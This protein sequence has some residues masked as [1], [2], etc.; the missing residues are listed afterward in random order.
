[1]VVDPRAPSSPGD[2]ETDVCVVGAGPAG[3]AFARECI[4]GPFRVCLLETGWF[5]KDEKLEAL[6]AGLV[7]SRHF[8]P[9]AL[10]GG[11]RR[12]FGGTANLWGYQTEPSSGRTYAR[13]VPPEPGDLIQRSWQPGSGWPCSAGQLQSFYARA[14]QLW[15]GGPFDYSIETW[16]DSATSRPSLDTSSLTSKIAQHGPSDVFT[17][18]YRDDI[19]TAPNIS[20]QLGSTAVRLESD[21]SGAV[22]QRAT[23]VRADGSTFSVTAK[24]FVLACGGVENVQLLLL[25]EATTPGGVGNRHGNVGC[26][27]TDHPE[28]RMGM[29][30]PAGPDV[31]DAIGLYD[32]H[33][34][35]QCMISGFLTLAEDVKQRERLLNVSAALVPQPAGFGTASERSLRSL[36]GARQRGRTPRAWSHV[37]TVLSSHRDTAAVL[38]A[39]LGRGGNYS[40]Y[41][42]GWSRPGVDRRRF[43]V[44]EVH[45]ATEQTAERDNSIAL[46][47][48]RD[49]M[50]RKQPTLRWRWSATDQENVAR[51]L[52]ILGEEFTSAGLG[53]YQ[54][55]VDFN[56]PVRPVY[57]GIHHP[58]G[59]TRMHEDPEQGVVNGECRVHGMENL[60]VA[61]SSVFPTGHGYANPTLTLLA[62]TIR[63]ADHVKDRM[64]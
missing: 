13:S 24:A 18:R 62:L 26:Y 43:K 55:W 10:A 37:R 3:I 59:G 32:L 64:T 63:L 53:T 44:I 16:A 61:G 21:R 20:V 25:S 22:V 31:M 51:S 14:Q 48:R 4:G 45:A 57:S 9:G 8:G 30:T 42:G 49:W 54:Q 19:F 17:L 27:V 46:S 2:I 50:G 47:D 23:V 5:E 1:M 28:F 15:N 41:Q 52:R 34:S 12:Q 36:L 11:R 58:M 40:E 38:R 7:E 29:I 35:G 60:Y 56:G 33:W 6:S 39:R